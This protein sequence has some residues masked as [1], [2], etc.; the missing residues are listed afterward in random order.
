M[1]I[2]E[3]ELIINADGSVFHLHMKPCQLADTVIVVGDP[4]RVAVFASL[5][6]DIEHRGSHR[7]FAFVTG[8][9]KGRRMT[10]L[11]T[12]IGTDNIDIVMNELEAL[13][14]LD[15]VTREFRPERRKLTVVR[16]GTCG[17]IQ[18]DVPTGSLIL[19]HYSIGFDGLMNWYADR[20]KI[21]DLDM[22]KAFVEHMNWLP[23]LPRPCIVRNS[24]KLI[25]LFSPGTVSAIT[26]SAPGF[27]GPQGRVIRQGL[28]MPDM[29]DRVESFRY[30]G[31]KI[32]NIEMEGSALAGLAAHFGHDA[33]TICVALANR[34]HRKADVVES[35]AVAG[36]VKF[37]LDRLAEMR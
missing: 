18:P 2:A 34:Y 23:A 9:Y 31:M 20:E 7:E 11:S 6:R 13:A 14:N 32:C 4:E 8:T 15:F 22:E 21:L 29:L 5:F 36:L 26:V 10:V 1:R 16:A 19:S 35:E 17:A 3:S 28:A 24:E 27:Y 25:K 37:T 33:I 30:A 12:G